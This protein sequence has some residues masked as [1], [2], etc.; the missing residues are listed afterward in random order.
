MTVRLSTLAAGMRGSQILQ[1][2]AEV[3]EL[4]ASGK[5]LCNLTVGDFAPSQ[6]PVPDALARGVA[7]QYA[8]GQTNYPPAN[9]MPEL[10]K[11]VVAFYRE[12]LGIDIGVGNTVICAGGRPVIY[13]AYRAL[14][15]P[16]DV[17]VYPTPSWSN[18]YYAPIAGGVSR[19]VPCGPESGF[20]PT[21]A[22]LRPA[23]K[24]A[25]LLVLN[26]P[27]NPAGTCFSERQLGDIC[28]AV[29]EENGRRGATDRPLYVLYDQ[30]YWMLTFGGVKHHT[31]VGLRKE[32]AKYTIFVDGISKAFAAT[33]MRVG[34]GVGPEDVIAAMADY[35]THVG[36]WAPRPE[37]LATAAVLPLGDEIRAFHGVMLKGLEARLRAMSDG[38]AAL[39]VKGHPVDST[40][41]Q[42]AMYLSAQFALAGK[43]TP[44]GV[45]LRTNEEIRR[46]LLQSAG[47][48]AV[49]FQAFGAREETGWFRL[50]VGA[51]SPS[52]IAGLLPRL[53]QAL[54]ALR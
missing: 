8:T 39:K 52:D 25:T 28:D 43:V 13:G 33:G 22:A 42:G 15:N 54:A 11:A 50:S 38:I 3:R 35:L 6:F 1:I 40:A 45:T 29:L 34:W 14:V 19:E 30:M 47:L 37:Q 48:A 21:A 26:S 9:G 10:R 27:M 7:H 4:A 17:V 23:L 46:Y 20:L 53:E 31:P 49:P 16:G 18:E 44:E 32:M 36:A 24:G 12:W 2:A 51:V 5:P 41:P